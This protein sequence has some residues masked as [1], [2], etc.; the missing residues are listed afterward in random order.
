M[1]RKKT[2]ELRENILDSARRLFGRFGP[3]KTTVDE[4]A[5][6]AGV[7]KGTVYYYFADKEDIF[8]RVIQEEAEE[9]LRRIEGAVESCEHP[10]QKLQAL[11]V[12]RIRGLG[13]L[14][15]LRWLKSCPEP[16]RW[17]GLVEEEAKL[18][19]SER[20]L[21]AD[22]LEGGK[23][24]GVFAFE[25]AGVIAQSLT[26]ILSALDRTWSEGLSLR[27]MKKRI[28]ETLRIVVEGLRARELEPEGKVH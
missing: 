20:A 14:W 13:E 4:I 22:I 28:E 16:R 26:N 3:R 17:R 24:S 1:V 12:E 23:A 27:E 19:R 21:V 5:L 8:L 25:D 11:F 6:E 10:V 15:N 9:L 7:G 18:S 2:G